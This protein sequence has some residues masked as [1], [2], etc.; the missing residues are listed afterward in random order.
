MKKTYVQT[1]LSKQLC[2]TVM[3]GIL[4]NLK[5][6]RLK[7]HQHLAQFFIQFLHALPQLEW[8]SQTPNYYMCISVSPICHHAP[9][10]PF[11]LSS[12]SAASSCQK[13][14]AFLG[15]SLQQQLSE[16]KKFSLEILKIVRLIVASE[17]G[18]KNKTIKKSIF[19]RTIFS[20]FF[21]IKLK[22]C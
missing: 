22:Q 10:F 9:Q 20:S 8:T 5:H 1:H 7:S 14:S 3:L 12:M 17:T 6:E 13:D 4:L 16:L 21:H 18:F 15:I 19:I 11:H 2:P